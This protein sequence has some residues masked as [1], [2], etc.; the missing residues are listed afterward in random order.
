MAPS[1]D[2]G[3]TVNDETEGIV[4]SRIAPLSSSAIRKSP[5]LVGYG[6]T[7]AGLSSDAAVASPPSP[8]Y[9]A[10]LSPATVEIVPVAETWRITSL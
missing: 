3:P 1:A 9:V 2:A 8:A 10:V 4:T 7:P 6:A 5:S